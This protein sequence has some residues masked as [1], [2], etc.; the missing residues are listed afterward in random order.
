MLDRTLILVA[1]ISATP[2]TLMALLAWRES[3]KVHMTVNSRMDELLLS[4]KKVSRA[5]G[6]EEGRAENA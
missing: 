4:E 1:L 3:R 6:K 2:P 5:E